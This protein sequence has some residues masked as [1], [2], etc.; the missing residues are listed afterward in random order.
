MVSVCMWSVSIIDT[1]VCVKDVCV[2]VV[3]IYFRYLRCVVF[4]CLWC[5]FILYV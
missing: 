1:D 3:S 2:S 5:S 4:L